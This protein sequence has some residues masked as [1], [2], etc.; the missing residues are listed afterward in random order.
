[1]SFKSDLYHVRMVLQ[2]IMEKDILTMAQ[3][4]YK[5]ANPLYPVPR[6]LSKEEIIEIY[7]MIK[8]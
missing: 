1:M 6:I 4:A 5:E 2:V 7:Y 3:R 8:E